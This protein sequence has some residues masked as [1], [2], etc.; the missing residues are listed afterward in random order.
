M[1]SGFAVSVL[2]FVLLRCSTS[3]Y[4]LYISAVSRNIS[5]RTFTSLLHGFAL[6]IPVSDVILAV[7]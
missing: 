1:F 4:L 7:L 2:L 6:G 5:D 3:T